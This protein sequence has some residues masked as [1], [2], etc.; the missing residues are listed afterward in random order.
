MSLAYKQVNTA[1]GRLTVVANERAVVAIHWDGEGPDDE[2][3][4]GG[5]HPVLAEATRQ[6]AEYFAG[7]RTTFDL[8]LEP[9]GTPFQK[10]VWEAL[11]RIPF[12]RTASYRDVAVA[13][14]SPNACRAVGAANGRNPI[15]IVVPCHRVIGA[16]GSLTG[17]GGGLEVKS[18]LLSHESAAALLPFTGATAARAR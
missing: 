8:P 14:G 15:P 4:A 10:R 13:I 18:F 7:T 1:I 17:F 11:T 12:G 9:D 2:A 5:A 16:S 6:L 3:V